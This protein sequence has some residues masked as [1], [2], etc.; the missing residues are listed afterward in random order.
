MLA[1][2]TLGEAADGMPCMASMRVS[3][4]TTASRARTMRDDDLAPERRP[5]WNSR[6]GT[7]AASARRH[8]A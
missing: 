4:S 1:L 6:N 2:T 7:L 3:D 5:N 8:A